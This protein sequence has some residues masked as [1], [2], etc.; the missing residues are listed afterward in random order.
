MT[1]VLLQTLQG[2]KRIITIFMLFFIAFGI[3]AQVTLRGKVKN[4]KGKVMDCA[5]VVVMN[6]DSP[7]KIIASTFTDENGQYQLVVRSDRD[8]LTLRVSQIGIE[9]FVIS[10][11][12]RSG[13]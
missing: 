6:P 4:T 13:E 9:P 5:V 8:S 2:I 1:E 3:S 7:K 10:I 11:P 12:N